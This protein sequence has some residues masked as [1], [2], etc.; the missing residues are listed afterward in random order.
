M[1]EPKNMHTEKFSGVD[2]GLPKKH[3]K[4]CFAF[5]STNKTFVVEIKPSCKTLIDV[6]YCLLL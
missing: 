4:F 5:L 2:Q 1:V 6:S 3:K